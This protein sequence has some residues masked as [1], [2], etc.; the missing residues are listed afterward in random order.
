M[1]KRQSIF[2]KSTEVTLDACDK[3]PDSVNLV[4]IMSARIAKAKLLFKDFLDLEQLV[5]NGVRG[6][7]EEKQAAR[8]KAEAEIAFGYDA[9]A[10]YAIEA[11]SMVLLEMAHY[12]AWTL[13]KI[14]GLTLVE[15][16]ENAVE[17]INEVAAVDLAKQGF[18]A[19]DLVSLQASIERFNE[20]LNKPEVAIKVRKAR[21]EERNAKFNLLVS[22]IKGPLDSAARPLKKKDARFYALYKVCRKLHLQG[23]RKKKTEE[24][25]EENV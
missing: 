10:S 3:N 9:L 16:G 19:S 21:V 13:S 2:I 14:D 15:L 17:K 5:M 25:L 18:E 22:F 7:R 11:E 8:E 1:T 24:T 23:S 12:S 6:I 20:W 4:P